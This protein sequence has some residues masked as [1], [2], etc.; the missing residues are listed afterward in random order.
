MDAEKMGE[1]AAERKGHGELRLTGFFNLLLDLQGHWRFVTRQTA[2]WCS[3]PQMS[4][5][6]NH[7]NRIKKQAEAGYP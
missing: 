5:T 1:T 6:C 4:V 2:G 3:L 7:N